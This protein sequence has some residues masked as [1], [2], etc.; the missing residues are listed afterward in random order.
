MAHDTRCPAVGKAV[1]STP[2]SAI[3]SWAVLPEAGDL[4][5]L[6]DLPLVRLE[7]DADPLVQHRDLGGELVDVVQ[8]HLQDEG[9]V[10]G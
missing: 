4:V 5:E 6:G 1:M 2:I 8:H 3:R 9:V 7:Q 10:G